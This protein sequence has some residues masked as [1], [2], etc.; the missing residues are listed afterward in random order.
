MRDHWLKI[1]HDNDARVDRFLETM[2]RDPRSP[3][4]GG[5]PM[6]DRYHDPKPTMMLMAAALAAYLNPDSRYR[7]DARIPEAAALALAYTAGV[8]NEDGT[9]DFTPVNFRSPPDTAFIV[10][11]MVVTYDL[12]CA[13]D[14]SR[15]AS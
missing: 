14:A 15:S 4:R 3:T 1:V 2:D 9:F 10:N 13:R 8:Q 6:E 5:V 11:R 12:L 7:G